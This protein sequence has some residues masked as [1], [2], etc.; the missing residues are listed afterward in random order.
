MP[1]SAES[2]VA[3]CTLV[4]AATG[5]T[6]V[7][8]VKT[9]TSL[10]VVET[11]TQKCIPYFCCPSTLIIDKGKENVNSEIKSQLKQVKV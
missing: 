10:A 9:K 11:L 7:H 3:V 4:D 1:K 5:F 2:H 6:I 8:P